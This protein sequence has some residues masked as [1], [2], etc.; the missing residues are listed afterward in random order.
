MEAPDEGAQPGQNAVAF[1]DQVSIETI[2]EDDVEHSTSQVVAYSEIYSEYAEREMWHKR[3]LET[4]QMIAR[5]EVN[6]AMADVLKGIRTTT[7]E[8]E[9]DYQRKCVAFRE[10]L[11]QFYTTKKNTVPVS[12]LRE[13]RDKPIGDVFVQPKLSHVTI[14][15]DGSRT[16]TEN[17]VH[18]CK[19]LLY[20]DGKLNSRV[21]IQGNPGMGKTTFL[22]ELALD[23]CDAVS[24]QNPDHNAI[25]S[26]VDTLKK[27]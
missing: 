9:S 23:W 10:R 19:D 3:N 8:T 11:I 18:Q 21:F 13:G 15:K 12:P 14:E 2:T 5:D 22:T 17:V 26:D 16:K 4:V 27:V 24:V 1:G 7:N 6:E 20:K 25:F